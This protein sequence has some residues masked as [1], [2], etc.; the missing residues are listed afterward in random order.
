MTAASF[1]WIVQAAVEAD[2]GDAPGLQSGYD[3][4]EGLPEFGEDQKLAGKAFQDLLDGEQLAA[5]RDR[6]GQGQKL[7]QFGAGSV[8]VAA[9]LDHLAQRAGHGLGAAAQLALQDHQRQAQ[10]FVALA[11]A[12]APADVVGDVGVEAPL[13]LAQGQ[14]ID[15]GTPF[16][17][18]DIDLAAPVADH[19]V[20]EQAAQRRRVLGLAM[21]G[22]IQKV[23]AEAA[24]RAQLAGREDGDQAV[25]FHQ[26]VLH[27]RGR[28]HEHIALADLVDELP[29]QRVAILELVGLVDDQ[30][31]VVARQDRARCAP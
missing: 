6:L 4:I 8:V 28:Q 23:A 17:K 20:V 29:G 18:V 3:G 30:Q 11:H 16:G 14:V 24:H 22:L 12:E 27:R 9:I 13:V 26:V 10:I 5:D 25:Q 2:G 7:A 1:C 31:I 21:V 19:D 15:G